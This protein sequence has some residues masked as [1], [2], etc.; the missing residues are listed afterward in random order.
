MAVTLHYCA[1]HGETKEL[2]IH[3]RLGAFCH[4]LGA[5]TGKNLA[6]Q[7]FA[8]VKDLGIMDHVSTVLIPFHVLL[9]DILY[10]LGTSRSTMQVIATP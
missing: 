4:V 5:H 10:R 8:I 6:L 1:E 3:S 9:T 7:F 2:E